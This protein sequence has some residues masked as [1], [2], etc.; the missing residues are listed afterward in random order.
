[1]VVVSLFWANFEREFGLI[2]QIFFFLRQSQRDKKSQEK[3]RMPKSARVLRGVGLFSVLG[4]PRCSVQ[5]DPSVA[6]AVL[7]GGV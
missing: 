6:K 7:S 3:T 5:D 2:K 1:M 4:P